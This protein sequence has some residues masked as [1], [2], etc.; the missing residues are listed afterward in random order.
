[1][2]ETLTENI[3][4]ENNLISKSKA[5]IDIHFPNNYEDL[6]KAQNRLKFEEIFFFQLGFGLKKQKSIATNKGQPFSKIG[7]YFN[8]FYSKELQFE[9]T[10]SQKKVIKEIR[11][12]LSKS[13]QMNR[14]LQGDVG[15][16]KTIV[17]Y[18]CC[19]I[20]KDNDFQSCIIAPTEILSQQ[21][22]K[23]FIE[24]SKNSDLNIKILT[25]STKTKQRREI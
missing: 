4:K 21:H 1:M 6:N 10:N 20:A 19:L 5:I 15:S 16:G 9:L 2:K 22:H 8:N 14:L 23:E 25:G 18:L 11:N 12:D 13:I 17:A 7:D 3:I 24:L